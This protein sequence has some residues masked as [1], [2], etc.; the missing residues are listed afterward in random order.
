VA[1]TGLVTALLAGTS[2]ITAT[3]EGMSGPA[4]L[5]VTA[6]PPPP[7]GSWPH[8]PSGFSL[9]SDYGF[10]D[11]VPVSYNPLGLGTSGWNVQWNSL[12]NG[13]GISDPGAPFSAPGVY[14]VKYPTGFAD[15]TAPSTV[16]YDFASR[17]TELYWGF[18]WKPSNPFQSDASGVNKIAFVFTPSGN[19]D[20]LYFDLSPNPWRIRCMDDLY[21]G[22]GPDAGKR[23][24]PNVAT[25][26]IALGQWHRIEIYVKYSTGSNADGI[27]QWWVDGVLNGSYSNLK[28]VQ[29]GGF[30][31]VQLSPTYGGNGGDVKSETDYF[32]FDHTHL[33]RP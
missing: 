23:D 9:I 31:H 10:G 1:P 4:G 25:T 26:V 32:W 27:V 6:L 29:D 30:N 12:G 7:S 16:E 24:E 19:T 3:S 22:G 11:P 21:A 14:Q 5:T 13:S 17:P 2:T 18:W 33:S 28:M 8:E 15:G 20:L